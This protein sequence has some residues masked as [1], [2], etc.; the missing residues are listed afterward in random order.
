MIYLIGKAID[1]LRSFGNERRVLPSCVALFAMQHG[2]IVR[3]NQQRS[4][5]VA[6]IAFTIA[7]MKIAK[8][9]VFLALVVVFAVSFFACHTANHASQ[10]TRYTLV[11]L[12][13]GEKKGLSKEESQKVF[14]GH[15]ANMSRLAKERRLLLAGP[16]GALRHD[17]A[18]RGI[19]V[20][21]TSDANEAK[22][23]AQTDPG[24]Q[25]GVFAMEYH[26]LETPAPLRAFLANELTQREADEAA[27]RK[28]APGEGG[29]G[30]VLLTAVNGK[31]LEQELSGKPFALLVGRL[32]GDRGWAILDAKDV[33][34]AEAL[35]GDLKSRI[36][37][38]TLDEWFASGGLEKL[39]SLR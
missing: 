16:Y 21:D 2:R 1:S 36:G 37:T 10:S 13:T 29:R 17:L 25:A 35:L 3:G 11:L 22:A 34:A 27:G 18:L 20:L 6:R 14:A 33:A 19:F 38:H 15:F 8:L 39:S 4:F 24:F 12:K 5:R 32:D 7:K 26:P 31:L 30:F 9:A 23:L 28:R